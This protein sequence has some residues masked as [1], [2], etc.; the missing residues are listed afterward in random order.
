MHLKDFVSKVVTEITSSTEDLPVENI[1]I[2]AKVNPYYDSVSKTCALIVPDTT[3]SEDP[4]SSVRILFAL[5]N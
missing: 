2:E 4:S 5:K 1:V 3:N